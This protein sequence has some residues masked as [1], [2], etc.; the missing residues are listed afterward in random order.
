MFWYGLLVGVVMGSYLGF[1]TATK[2]LK[3]KLGDEYKIDKLRAKKG[4][5][6]RVDQ[7]NSDTEPPSKVISNKKQRLSLIK[8]IKA[9]K[10]LKRAN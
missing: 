2:L 7:L 3:D 8:R 1:I 5:S 10:A 6:I 4:G 9:K